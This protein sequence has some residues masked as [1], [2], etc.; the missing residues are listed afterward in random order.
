VKFQ[1]GDLVLVFGHVHR[2]LAIACRAIDVEPVTTPKT[3]SVRFPPQ[4][5]ARQQRGFWLGRPNG[6][7]SP[8]HDGYTWDHMEVA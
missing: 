6:R 5:L 7:R 2:I 3:A 4:W 1:V 8:T